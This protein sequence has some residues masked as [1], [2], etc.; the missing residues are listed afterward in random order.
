MLCSDLSL[1]TTLFAAN[2]VATPAESRGS[3]FNDDGTPFALAAS[4]S[5]VAAAQHSSN[6]AAASAQPARPLV[7]TAL[8]RKRVWVRVVCLHRS[9][10]GGTRRVTYERFLRAGRVASWRAEEGFIVSVGFRDGAEFA[11]N[12]DRTL[13]KHAPLKNVLV[14]RE[15][16]TALA[17]R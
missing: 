2:I 5:A 6:L 15:Q 17:R 16:A 12:G 8:A 3:A 4:D 11:L 10:D 7:L 1:L 13:F 14:R 9:G